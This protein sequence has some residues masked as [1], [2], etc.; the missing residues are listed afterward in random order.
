MPEEQLHRSQAEFEAALGRLKEC[1]EYEWNQICKGIDLGVVGPY[2]QNNHL[3]DLDVYR[4]HWDVSNP[5]SPKLTAAMLVKESNTAKMSVDCERVYAATQ[6]VLAAV[7]HIYMPS[8]A[9]WEV[10]AEL[11]TRAEQMQWLSDKGQEWPLLSQQL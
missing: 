1:T 3:H 11:P 8:D 7:A 9:E 4:E 6:Q 10:F 5:N 2:L